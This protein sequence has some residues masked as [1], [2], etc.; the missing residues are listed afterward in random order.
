[1]V[2]LQNEP[3]GRKRGLVVE[4]VTHHIQEVMIVP[5]NCFDGGQPLSALACASSFD[6]LEQKGMHPSDKESYGHHQKA[7]KRRSGVSNLHLTMSW[8]YQRSI[9]RHLFQVSL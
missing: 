3:G 9:T 8:F 4:A 6:K 1:M 5:K 7:L 2:L